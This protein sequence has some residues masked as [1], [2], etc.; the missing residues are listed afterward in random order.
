MLGFSRKPQKPSLIM[1][2]SA[3]ATTQKAMVKF[4]G[5]AGHEPLAVENGAGAL[6]AAR[7]RPVE[8]I[9]LDT[10]LS[11]LSGVDLCSRLHENVVTAYIPIILMLEKE[12]ALK[13]SRLMAAGAIDRLLKP[14]EKKEA[15]SKIK[16]G[17]ECREHWRNMTRQGVNQEESGESEAFRKFKIF[18][19][20]R[21]SLPDLTRAYLSTASPEALYKVAGRLNIN[22]RQMA[23]FIAEFGARPYQDQFDPEDV[24]AGALPMPLSKYF[25]LLAVGS[26]S[27]GVILLH[28]NPFIPRFDEVH[29][30]LAAKY[31]PCQLVVCDPNIINLLFEG[32]EYREAF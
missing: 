11:D 15:L 29:K 7:A 14:P 19:C 27:G 17:L 2:A 4:V 22:N 1:I 12:Q 5:K 3:E 31:Q 26:P 32:P 24:L 23:E 28:S 21:L 6:A 25:H 30:L 13:P 9:F 20:D 16:T 18:L 8:L 10:V